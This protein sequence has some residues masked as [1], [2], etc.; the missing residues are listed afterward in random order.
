MEINQA[1]VDDR[2]F[3]N[4]Y[5]NWLQMALEKAAESELGDMLKEKGKS[6]EKALTVI[7]ITQLLLPRSHY[8]H[9]RQ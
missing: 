5:S 4:N 2:Q 7:I 3:Q 1:L 9:S 6:N 8:V